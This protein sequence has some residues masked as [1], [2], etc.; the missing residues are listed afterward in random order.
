MLVTTLGLSLAMAPSATPTAPAATTPPQAMVEPAAVPV[1][2]PAVSEPPTRSPATDPSTSTVEPSAVAPLEPLAPLGV[3]PRPSSEGA[4]AIELPRWRGTGLFV[5]S[6]ILGLAG[7]STKLGG[8][9][10]GVREA[11]EI[12]RTGVLPFCIDFCGG[13]GII[14]NMAATPLIMTSEALLSGGLSR[15]GRWAAHR[16]VANGIPHDRRKTGLMIGL[17]LGAIG[18]G[19]A[20]WLATRFTFQDADTYVGKVA[21]REL[22]WWTSIAA[23]Y[24]GMGVLGYGAG[25]GNAR[26]Q[27]S[28][29]SRFRAHVAPVL[30]RQLAGVGVSGRF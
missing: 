5:A 21:V 23:V 16:D 27:L 3:E 11:R 13:G 19:F 8:T 12:D 18:I 1:Q 10:V 14:A 30:T 15:Y 29:P 6:G 2:T 7:L 17:G 26:W 9:V 25:Y 20:S 28:L 4:E 24:G 22:G